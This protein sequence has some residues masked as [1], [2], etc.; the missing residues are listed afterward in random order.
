MTYTST[1]CENTEPALAPGLSP[2]GEASSFSG[3]LL[4][5]NPTMESLQQLSEQVDETPI[6]MLNF[7]RFRPRGDTSIYSLYGKEAAPEVKKVGSFIGYYGKVVDDLPVEF[8]FDTSWDGIV[9]PVYHRRNSY[10]TMQNSPKYQL[11][12]PYRTAGTSRRLLYPLVDTLEGQLFKET[13]NIS[14]FD[15]QRTGINIQS[16]EIYIAE[17][18]RFNSDTEEQ[19]LAE[20]YCRINSLLTNVGAKAVLSVN[21]EQ[22]VLSEDTWQHFVLICFPSKDALIKLY[23][24]QAWKSIQHEK[25]LLLENSV[26]LATEGIVLPK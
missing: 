26:S 15:K 16:G 2:A 21:T 12:I 1:L 9:I 7:L 11:A 10:L 13:A 17:L 22:P 24:S 5:V 25:L 23:G 18:L 14:D 4:R 8:G 3:C 19:V 20:L 6:L